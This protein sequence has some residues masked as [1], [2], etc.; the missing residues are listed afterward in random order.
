MQKGSIVSD[1][2]VAALLRR[3]DADNDD[4]LSFA[5]F[6]R[7]LLPYFIYGCESKKENITGKKRPKSSHKSS[8]SISIKPHQLKNDRVKS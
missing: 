1:T 3:M 4:E 2:D 6:F 5:D 7:C 8:V